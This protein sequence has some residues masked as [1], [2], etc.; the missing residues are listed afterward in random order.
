M[1]KFL[2]II[3]ILIFTSCNKHTIIC[4]KEYGIVTSIEMYQKY[5]PII[6]IYTDVY[7]TGVQFKDTLLY[8]ILDK[9]L[10]VGDSIPRYVYRHN[11]KITDIKENEVSN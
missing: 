8:I 3:L 9:E 6:H 11:N 7:K 10:I 2:I 1:K 4:N 5:N